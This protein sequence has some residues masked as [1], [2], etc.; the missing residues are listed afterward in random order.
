MR[1]I[2]TLAIAAMLGA[3]STTANADAALSGT[4][5]DFCAPS[6]AGCTQLND[7]EGAIPGLVTGMVGSNLVGGLPTAGANINAGP[8]SAANFAKWYT[9]S[10]GFNS[11]TP[12]SLTLARGC[13][14]QILLQ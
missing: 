2:K 8:S 1:Q 14:R 4:I 12:F 11:S 9:D 6:I 10:P 7:F 13:E 5:R 3:A